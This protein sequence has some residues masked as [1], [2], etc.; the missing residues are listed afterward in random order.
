MRRLLPLV[1]V[2]AAGC[3]G[4]IAGPTSPG[5]GTTPAQT[6]ATGGQPT[7][8]AGG[9]GATTPAGGGQATPGGNSGAIPESCATG[10]IAY[11]KAIEPLASG[12]D[13]ATATLGDFFTAK[14][15]I[16]EKGV[17]ILM[18]NGATA[19][20]SCPEV[21]L[22]FA[23]FDSRSPWASIL[24]IATADAPGTVA[25]LETNQQ[26]SAI[27]VG[28]MADYG[29]STCDDAVTQIKAGVAAATGAGMA[30]AADMGVG[31][32]IALLGLYKTYLAGVRD[33]ACT[34]DALGNDEF[35]F[36]GAIG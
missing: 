31:E 24:Q 2:V 1:L 22:E 18:E 33:G 4:A 3:G 13:P 29:A 34:A 20:Y 21:G 12:F 10:F 32:G 26:V 25:W 11:L 30:K 7:T 8:G 19:T 23:Y 9:P 36:F 35:N 6:S 17:E 27:D 5:G 15:A 28:Q 14:E 16:S